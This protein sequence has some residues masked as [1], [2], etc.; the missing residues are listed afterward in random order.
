MI[1]VNYTDFRILRVQKINKCQKMMVISFAYMTCLPLPKKTY[2]DS[3]LGQAILLDDRA[4]KHFFCLTLD[5]Q[6]YTGQ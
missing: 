6:V 5:Q 1:T 2:F 4:T 3:I